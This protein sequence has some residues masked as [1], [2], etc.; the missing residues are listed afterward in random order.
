LYTCKCTSGIP[1]LNQNGTF[2]SPWSTI[3]PENYD[4]PSPEKW[5]LEKCFPFEMDFFSRD[6]SFF[7][8]GCISLGARVDGEN[9]AKDRGARK[10][11]IFHNPAT[12]HFQYLL[13]PAAYR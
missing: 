1:Y 4:V 13:G 10:P 2:Q 8:K 3:F 7:L 9:L 5:W 11:D 12:V 6:M